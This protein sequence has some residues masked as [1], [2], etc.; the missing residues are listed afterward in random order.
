[1]KSL[2]AANIINME[3][4]VARCLKPWADHAHYKGNIVQLWTVYDFLFLSYG[5]NPP[6]AVQS[7]NWWVVLFR[8]QII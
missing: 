7:E 3:I 5:T 8:T 4:D 2:T 6:K 1:M